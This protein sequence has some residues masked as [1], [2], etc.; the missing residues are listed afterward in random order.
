ALASFAVGGDHGPHLASLGTAEPG[1]AAGAGDPQV[2]R[3]LEEAMGQHHLAVLVDQEPGGEVRLRAVPD[4][5]CG[6]RGPP[7]RLAVPGVEPHRRIVRTQGAASR[8]GH[9][10]MG[11]GGGEGG[12]AV[13]GGGWWAGRGGAG[14]GLRGRGAGRG[15]W[16][17]YI[18]IGSF[19]GVLYGNAPY[20]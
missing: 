19:D 10:G 3:L 16:C 8:K 2:L 14:W 5:P 9:D 11:G 4:R 13:G 18:G 20:F 17:E 1:A 6:A 15:W 12:C 7:R